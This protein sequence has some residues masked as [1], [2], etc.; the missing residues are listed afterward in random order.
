V[1]AGSAALATARKDKD[2]D[3]ETPWDIISASPIHTVLTAALQASNLVGAVDKTGIT[4]F[5]PNDEQVAE[6]LAASTPGLQLT[7][8]VVA[9]VLAHHVV[10]R[11]KLRGGSLKALNGIIY[12]KGSKDQ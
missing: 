2:Q 4:V 5:A 6:L 8:P 11:S 12:N 7:S 10:T 3:K 9:A 1:P